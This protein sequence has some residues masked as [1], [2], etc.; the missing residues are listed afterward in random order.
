MARAN[1]FWIAMCAFVL[2]GVLEWTTLSA[3]TIR[4][5][6]GPN[7]EPLLDVSIRGVALMVL[8][9]LA[10]RSWIHHRRETLEERSRS[11]QE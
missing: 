6:N 7:G 1:R 2:L 10:F 4:V 3:E 8:A 9:L 11:G 5:V